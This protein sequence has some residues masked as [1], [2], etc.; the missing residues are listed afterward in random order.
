MEN[1]KGTFTDLELLSIY[2]AAAIHDY[3]HPGVNNNFLI[4]TSDP[5]ALL[6]NDKSVLENHHCS[7]A[8]KVLTKPENNFLS[9]LEKKSFKTVRTNIVEMVLATDLALHFDLLTKFKKRVLTT[10]S[11]D[12]KNNTDDKNVLMQVLMK[13][14]DV[15]NPTK[16]WSV[17]SE[18]IE[19]ITGEFHHQ[20]D[21]ERELGLEI[22][23]F[24]NRLNE[25]N[26]MNA[27]KGFIEFI[28]YPLYEALECWT[29]ITIF[30]H[31]LDAHR[32]KFCGIKDSK[33]I[34]VAKMQRKR[35]NST[36]GLQAIRI[37][38]S[39]LTPDHKSANEFTNSPTFG[40]KRRMSAFARRPSLVQSVR[41]LPIFQKSAGYLSANEGQVPPHLTIDLDPFDE[42]QELKDS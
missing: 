42:D 8:F 25:N 14:A 11:F 29:P 6:Y 30:K 15:S 41:Q 12:P 37:D 16:E 13:C 28:V 18:W 19:R 40:H 36:A 39:R 20:G 33:E 27:Q 10:N 17:Y 34:E 35:L 38:P 21:L 3:D 1:I 32:L 7:S 24:M 4:A 2:L 23:P 5:R 31:D 22:S 26:G 9:S